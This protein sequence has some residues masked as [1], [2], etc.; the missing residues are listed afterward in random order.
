MLM[1][2]PYRIHEHVY[3]K[4]DHK[5]TQAFDNKL[6]T[7]LNIFIMEVIFFVSSFKTFIMDEV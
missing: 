4:A 7:V 3:D 6:Q 1:L 5:L 2:N